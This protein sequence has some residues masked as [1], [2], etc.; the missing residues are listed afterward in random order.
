[1][2]RS[3]ASYKNLEMEQN[4]S[5]EV[6]QRNRRDSAETAKGLLRD[7]AEGDSVE[8]ARRNRRDNSEIAQWQ[9]KE[10]AKI[11]QR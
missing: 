6:F 10:I 4:H 8:V 11:A 7:S 1:V 2:Y 5:A 9:R 3:S